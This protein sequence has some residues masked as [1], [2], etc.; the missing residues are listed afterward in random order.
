MVKC[1]ICGSTKNVIKHHDSY[2]PEK[3]RYLCRSCHT[4]YHR[5]LEKKVGNIGRAVLREILKGRCTPQSIAEQ[6]NT[7][8]H[9][10]HMTL[11]VFKDLGIVHTISHGLYEMTPAGITAL[12]ILEPLWGGS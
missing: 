2:Y 9:F 4:K 1:E 12:G 6:L 10:V 5:S 3:I 11:A 7:K 8:K